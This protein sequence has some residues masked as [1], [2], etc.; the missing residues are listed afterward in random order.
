[1]DRT[2]GDAR[3][4]GAGPVPTAESCWQ[5]LASAALLDRLRVTGR[6]RPTTD[7]DLAADL[8]SHLEHGVDGAL[9]GSGAPVVVTTDRLTRAL[10][11]TVHATADRSGTQE[12]SL[13]L[14][15]GAL[16]GV[17]FRQLV[18][19]GT[20]GD[21]LVDGLDA[22]AVDEH[23]V[24]LVDWIGQLEPAARSEL[25]AEVDR[26]AEGLRRRWPPLDPVWL[27]RTRECV[28]VSLAGGGIELVTRI[29]LA[30]GRPAAGEASVALVDVTSGCRRGEHRADR[31]LHALAETLR[32]TTPPFVVAT[33]FTRSGELD[34]D[35]VTPELLVAAARRCRAGIEAMAPQR[36]DG[37]SSAG[38]RAPTLDGYPWC[39]GCAEG[40]LRRAAPVAAI[41]SLPAPAVPPAPPARSVTVDGVLPVREDRAA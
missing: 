4:V 39:A 30:I 28:R 3:H 26:Q 16:V 34:V 19:T 22:L 38:F 40:P 6:A 15:C 23:R 17:L 13:P 41:E 24:P 12:Y 14:A 1:M 20:I 18:A 7:P 5:P 25:R 10:S 29:D 36:A 9:G 27:P 37:A 32:S 8:R 35:P 11:C 31:H 21:A 2:P 33:Y